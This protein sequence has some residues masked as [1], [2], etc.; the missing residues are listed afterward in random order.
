[1]KLSYNVPYPSGS[2]NMSEEMEAFYEFYDSDKQTMCLEFD[3]DEEAKKC[4]C[5]ISSARWRRDLPVEVKKVGKKVY[6]KKVAS[7]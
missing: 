4:A 5:K 3:T 6:V 2:K 7:E 1:M